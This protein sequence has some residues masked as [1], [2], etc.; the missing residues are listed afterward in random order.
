MR[1]GS[2]DTEIFNE[3]HV[4]K[5]YRFLAHEKQTEIRLIDPNRKQPPASRF[6][7]NE[8]EFV[9]VCR[10][11]NGRYNIYVGINERKENG[12]EA[13]DVVSV[14]TI[15][16]DLDPSRPKTEKNGH[17]YPQAS[18]GEE[19]GKANIMA[20]QLQYDMLQAGYKKPVLAMSGNGYQAWFSVPTIYINDDNRKGVEQ[21]IQQFQRML[22]KTYSKNGV[23]VDNIGDL[24]RIIKVMGTLSIK[25]DDTPERP[26]RMARW[27]D[28]SDVERREDAKLWDMILSMKVDESKPSEEIILDPI[29]EEKF[30]M[31]MK[32]DEKFKDLME[33]NVQIGEPPSGAAPNGLIKYK[34]RS[35]AEQALV[36]KMVHYGMPQAQVNS[37]MERCKLGKWQESND[38]YKEL[39]YKKAFD[40]QKSMH[41][42]EH[43]EAGALKASLYEQ[44]KKL[45]EKETLTE[46]DRASIAV[47]DKKIMTADTDEIGR[48][49]DELVA[50]EDGRQKH[51]LELAKSDDE[52]RT[53]VKFDSM[54][55][56][57][58]IADIFLRNIPIKTIKDNG[59]IYIFNESKGIWE[60]VGIKLISGIC[61]KHLKRYA[62]C[63]VMKE[64]FEHIKRNTYVNRTDF[65]TDATKI[66]LKNCILDLQTLETCTFSKDYLY[67]IAM[68]VRYDPKADCPAWKAFLAEKT[69]SPDDIQTLQEYFGFCLLNDMRFQKSLLIYGPRR[70]GK[71]T[72]LY[73]IGRL[74]GRENITAM[75][76]HYIN[77][78]NFAMAYLYG[79]KANI[80]ADLPIEALRSISNFMLIAGEDLITSDKKHQHQISFYNIAKP[81]FSCNSIPRV[82]VQEDAFYRRW[83]ILN[84]PHETP[85][86]GVDSKLKQ[87][88]NTEEELSGILNWAIEG[89]KSIL[90]NDIIHYNKTEDEIKEI[91][92][93][94]S[95]SVS[96]F[97]N[98]RIVIDD[99]ERIK[100][101]EVYNIYLKY[102]QDN[103]LR[104]MNIIGFGRI[105]SQLTGCGVGKDD[106]LPAY[107]GVKLNKLDDKDVNN[108]I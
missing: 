15:V 24:P 21:K 101:R 64:V 55:F 80:C 43:K 102:C 3:E 57:Y 74:L 65:N 23:E 25:G 104:P 41:D 96:S 61:G 63:F 46:E 45:S 106:E 94:N 72:V 103:K 91:W 40:Y 13:I 26:Y 66:V 52:T 71:S 11:F 105:F 35:E 20:C 12:T 73:I 77:E 76:L 44:R 27:N 4:R 10:E 30:E 32:S 29:T 68:P 99:F 107:I 17:K 48:L 93:K 84:F 53:P 7:N 54:S 31:I 9:S 5:T 79:K 81:I 82:P 2:M 50:R 92:N 37:F 6:V 36:N 14:K 100:K 22:K 49:L 19:L 47:I 89:A 87:K 97:I 51:N 16:S 59:D 95:D 33:G 67:T 85:I 8:D 28:L 18:T 62:T 38:K 34:S 56:N 98:T 42:I 83:I 60:D 90:K 88:L 1:R 78:N 39:T 70:A 58:D 75:S 108:D 69:A 86:E